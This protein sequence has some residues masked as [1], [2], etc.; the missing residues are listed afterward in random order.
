[1]TSLS[2]LRSSGGELRARA[3]GRSMPCSWRR[4]AVSGPAT[5]AAPPSSWHVSTRRLLPLRLHVGRENRW[6]HREAEREAGELDVAKGRS[7]ERR[8][9]GCSAVR[10]GHGVAGRKPRACGGLLQDGRRAQGLRGA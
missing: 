4:G 9:G 7:V 2:G 5:P 10:R 1:E 6:L 8:A 3:G